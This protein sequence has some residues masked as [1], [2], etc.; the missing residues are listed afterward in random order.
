[1]LRRACGLRAALI[2][3][4]ILASLAVA[5]PAFAA[6]THSVCASGCDF[7]TIQAAIN[8]VG[9]VDGDTILVKDGTYDE[10]VSVTKSL[11]VKSENGAVTTTI[12]GPIGGAG[13][14]AGT[15]VKVNAS[16]V[17]VD[18]FTITR[19][20]DNTTDWNN[21]NLNTAGVAVQGQAI[22][23]AEIR[24]SIFTG[25]RTGIDVNN[26]NGVSIHNNTIDNNRTGLIFRNQTDNT[27]L[28]ENFITNNWTVGALFLDASGGTNSPVQSAV[29]S[30]FS[31]NDIS[32]NWYGGIV[33][34]Q[35]GGSLP[36]PPAN[37]KNFSANW[38]GTSTPVVTTANSTE[39]GY[40]A[41]IPVA[42]GGT[43]APPGGQPD[44]AGPASANFDYTPML[45]SGT[46]TNVSTGSGT[47]GFQGSF[48]TLNVH[49][50]GAQTGA[51]ERIGEGVARVTTG[52]TINVAAGTYVQASITKSLTLNGAQAGVDARGRSAS[53]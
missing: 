25:L 3:S 8:D 27:N 46:D 9:T 37:G 7:A 14:D 26:T 41:Q 5:A 40:A 30:T 49:N 19:L 38:F 51:T 31:G 48:G 47:F 35:S 29:N 10:D 11:T 52:G 44:I 24:N 39:P 32:G 33:D 43:A 1:M 34:R 12:R 45:A 36:T 21:T 15:T 28:S 50:G 22:T 17:V 53:E 6:S 23:G 2:V 13:P 20:G 18:G 4:S 42:F 16:G